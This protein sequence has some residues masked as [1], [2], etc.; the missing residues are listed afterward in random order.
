MPIESERFGTR[1][2]VKAGADRETSVL[3]TLTHADRRPPHGTKIFQGVLHLEEGH[4]VK[5]GRSRCPKCGGTL[6]LRIVLER[7]D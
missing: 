3:V 2:F 4:K 7:V 6:D 1:P 5:T